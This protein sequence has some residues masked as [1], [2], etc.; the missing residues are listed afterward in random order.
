MSEIP[1]VEID[2]HEVQTMLSDPTANLLLIDCRNQDEY[3]HCR[4]EGSVLIP[5]GEIPN[6]LSE[7]EP[8][9][10]ATIVVHCHHGMRSLKAATFLRHNG[11]PHAQSMAGGID[12]WSDQID[13]SVAKY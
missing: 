13:S 6:R 10:D 8:R 3:D 1:P 4:I 12:V 7:I 9:Q 11:F 5:L 2:V